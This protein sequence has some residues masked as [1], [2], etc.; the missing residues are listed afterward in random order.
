MALCPLFKLIGNGEWYALGKSK[1]PH[2]TVYLQGM[3]DIH[4]YKESPVFMCDTL[5]VEGC[6]NNWTWYQHMLH[7]LHSGAYA[8]VEK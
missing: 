7:Y 1:V 8:R 6:D 5:F 4:G 3:V 2:P